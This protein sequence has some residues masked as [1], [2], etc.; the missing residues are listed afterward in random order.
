MK[1]K[2]EKVELSKTGKSQG[3]WIAGQKYTCKDML[4]NQM[5]GKEID[6]VVGSFDYNGKAYPTIESY[7]V[8]VSGQ[9]AQS[10]G[11]Q[12]NNTNYM[13]FV[14]NT[15]AHAISAGLIKTP[16]EIKDW[17]VAAYLAADQL[18]TEAELKRPPY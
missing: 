4:I 13:P 16:P 11:A 18:E 14:S 10:S 5:A 12:G 17:A 7:T 1:G 3:V 8:T 2:I 9:E 6:F 15:V